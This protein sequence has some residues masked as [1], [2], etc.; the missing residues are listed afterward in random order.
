MLEFTEDI[1]GVRGK[2]WKEGKTELKNNLYLVKFRKNKN[3]VPVN[4][5]TYLIILLLF[6]SDLKIFVNST[7][8]CI[9]KGTAITCRNNLPTVLPDRVSDVIVEDFIRVEINNDTFS[10]TSWESVR[11]LDIT[12]NRKVNL[13]VSDLSFFPLK[14]LKKLGV[15]APNMS[16]DGRKTLLWGLQGLQTLNLSSCYRL[17]TNDLYTILNNEMNLETL[18][19]DQ[20]CMYDGR[21]LIADNTFYEMLSIV[22]IKR[23]SLSGC[24]MLLRG[25]LNLTSFHF[26]LINLDIS[27]TTITVD[28]F[29]SAVMDQLKKI[30]D[31]L[32]SIDISYR[33]ERF[34]D[35]DYAATNTPCSNNSLENI[36]MNHVF[37]KTV[38]INNS[39]SDWSKCDLKLKYFQLRSNHLQYYNSTTIWPRNVQLLYVDLSSNNMEYLSPNVYGSAIS[40]QVFLLAHNK[41]HLM[42]TFREFEYLFITFNDLVHLDLSDNVLSWLP[43]A[44]FRNNCNLAVLNLSH[45]KL[46]SVNFELRHLRHLRYLNLEHNKILYLSVSDINNL[47]SIMN[48]ISTTLTLD[49]VGNQFE[50]CCQSVPF[51]TWLLTHAQTNYS[52]SLEG[53]SVLMNSNVVDNSKFLCVRSKIILASVLT[54]IGVIGVITS[55]VVLFHHRKRRR[56]LK[57]TRANF[58]EDFKD[59][60]LPKKFL[61]YMA[62]SSEDM[63]DFAIEIYRCLEESLR[64]LTG[65]EQELICIGD[66]FFQPGYP[67]VDE[68]FRCI[69]ESCV[70]V[71]IVSNTFC[72]SS[73]CQMEVRE[74]YELNKPI[75]LICTEHVDLNKMPTLLFNIFKN[76]TRAKITVNENRIVEICPSYEGLSKSILKL[77]IS[78]Y[79]E[80]NK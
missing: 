8:D 14:T 15:H 74:A 18:I 20:C 58:L 35:T 68:I 69:S 31:H 64:G 26:S 17:Q 33:D 70:V 73:W 65:M 76:F 77:C 32:R 44:I 51:I 72:K 25:P 56:K 59:K 67:I 52:C 11:V 19:L 75:I 2:G 6:G 71:F 79:E 53:H 54:S 57:Y 10:H 60:V 22:D 12:V 47:D 27:N 30:S 34:W 3:M 23:L 80:M 43:G 66:R 9:T 29:N 40:L 37:S 62:F 7:S 48:N 36:T 24:N 63:E 28:K 38:I 55:L 50:C 49:L 46:T 45:N 39:I 16:F 5:N 42:S 13:Y 78:Q 21:Q 41:L 1:L 61:C 4:F